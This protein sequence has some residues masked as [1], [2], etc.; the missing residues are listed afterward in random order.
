LT[1]FFADAFF[2]GALSV[3][4]ITLLFGYIASYGGLIFLGGGGGGKNPENEKKLGKPGGC[5]F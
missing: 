5:L 1:A 3:F 2:F 4:F